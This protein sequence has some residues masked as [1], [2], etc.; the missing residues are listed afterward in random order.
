MLW[1]ELQVPL[2]MGPPFGVVPDPVA[3]AL[4][5]HSARIQGRQ[6][7]LGVQERLALQRN[8]G[9]IPRRSLHLPPLLRGAPEVACLL[10]APEGP[11][12]NIPKA[13]LA[14]GLSQRHEAPF[15]GM[16]HRH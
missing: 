6:G 16:S 13:L 11:T 8:F 7:L 15:E 14:M 10:C 4:E 12:L 5:L 3:V 9:D 1:H 2:E